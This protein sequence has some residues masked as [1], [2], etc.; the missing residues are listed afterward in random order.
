[1]IL[2]ESKIARS[3]DDPAL[4]IEV[5]LN[6]YAAL[7]PVERRILAAYESRGLVTVCEDD[8][9]EPRPKPKGRKSK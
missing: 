7:S 3:F 6:E 1:V 4:K 9:E 8:N 5:G 2:V